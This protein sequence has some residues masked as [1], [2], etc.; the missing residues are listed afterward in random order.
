MKK[1]LELKINLKNKDRYGYTAFH[2]ACQNGHIRIV[3]MMIEQSKSLELDLKAE[4]SDGQ[5]GYQRAKAYRE[6]D[7]VNLIQTKMPSL[8][9]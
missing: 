8:V 5:T 2:L 4:D 3:D 6:T 7:V 1:S 9:V